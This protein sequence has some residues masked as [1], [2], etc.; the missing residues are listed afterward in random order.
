MGDV[1]SAN[2]GTCH[3]VKGRLTWDIRDFDEAVD[4]LCFQL[5]AT[6]NLYATCRLA[7]DRPRSI[8]AAT[9]P[10]N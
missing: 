2:V 9:L 7:P 10:P 5:G 4:G 8:P 1:Y 3:D 6:C